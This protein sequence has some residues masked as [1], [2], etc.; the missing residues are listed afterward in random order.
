MPSTYTSNLGIELPADGEKDGIWGDIINENMDILDRATNGSLSLSLSGTSSTLTTSNG[1]LSDGQY[2]LLVLTGS[3]SG[4]HTITLESNLAQK[5]YFV[6]NTTAQSVVFTQGSGG[7]ATIAAGDS[8]TIYANGAGSS[9]AVA[10]L[11]T[12][13]TSTTVPRTST[14]GAAQI[15]TG[16]TGQRPTAATGQFRFNSDVAKF[17]GYNGSAWGS[18]G[19]GATGGGADEIF[20]QNGQ[21]VTTNYTIPADKNAM[22][23]GPITINAG[24]TVTVSTGARY[25]VI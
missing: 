7:N 18:V 17:E 6:R 4:T 19:G 22:S 23:T 10:L 21:V 11:S 14:I 16:T 1:V 3:P 13:V 20:V 12:V 9:A 2:K 24:V 5:I 15:P 8:A 25:V